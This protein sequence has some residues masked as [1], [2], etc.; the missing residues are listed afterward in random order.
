MAGKLIQN[1]FALILLGS[2][3]T[4]ATAQDTLLSELYGQGVH[5]YF[6][7]DAEKTHEVLTMAID[8]GSRDPRCF[9]FRG[10]AYHKLGR[11]EEG[12]A[13][14]KRGAELEAAGEAVQIDIGSSLQRIQGPTRLQ[15]ESLRYQA[16]LSAH[17]TDVKQRQERYEEFRSDEPRV[18]RRSDAGADVKLPVTPPAELP[19]DPFGGG[20]GGA[21]API[22]P[23]TTQPAAPAGIDEASDPFA[24]PVAPVVVPPE[25]EEPPAAVAPTDPFGAPAAP[26]DDPFGAPAAPA[27]PGDDLFGA[28]AA[29]MAPGADPFGA[30][31]APAAPGDDLFGAP[32]APAAPGDRSVRCPRG[33]GRTW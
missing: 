13:D 7:G 20:P 24:D 22:A 5:S 31:A 18:I 6:A 32:A 27:A 21:A 17:V 8:R 14:F 30:P 23:T 11:P 19:D 26:G 10:L 16:R 25:G 12:E 4:T 1:L 33:S 29:P 28:P 2:A 9:Y 3:V 15:L